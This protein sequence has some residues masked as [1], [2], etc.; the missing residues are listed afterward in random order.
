MWPAR[1]WRLVTCYLIL[2][3]LIWVADSRGILAPLHRLVQTFT[4]PAQS[5]LYQTKQNLIA[6][7]SWFSH[8]NQTTQEIEK[9]RQDSSSLLANLH[10]LK[11]VEEENR[12]L[13][14]LLGASLPP[15]WKFS[16]AKVVWHESDVLIL[17]SDFLPQVGMAA[18]APPESDK[19]R[20]GVFVGRVFKVS[21]KRIEVLLPTG[22][23]SKIPVT[24]NNTDGGRTA[25]GLLVGKGG[26]A[27]LDQV[28]TSETIGGGYAVL[29]SGADGLPGGKAGLPPGLLLGR[30][31]KV[32]PEESGTWKQAE[33]ELAVDI[34]VIE[35]VFFVTK[36]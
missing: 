14:R 33:V 31:E 22:R 16:P 36:H 18:V 25:S 28:L 30:I 7:F 21:D 13:R 34:E 15:S 35:T 3:I 12:N 27:M 5:K 11:N 19:A 17:T 4:I 10:G 32:L 8:K 6:P 20:T 2:S 1:S 29:T 9:L 24:V 23:D 26:K